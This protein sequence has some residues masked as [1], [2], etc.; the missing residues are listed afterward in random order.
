MST[1]TPPT[2][3][4]EAPQ[5]TTVAKDNAPTP[6]Q[7][8]SF[9]SLSSF[10]DV[11]ASMPVTADLHKVDIGGLEPTKAA[12][13]SGAPGDLEKAA[14]PK[15]KDGKVEGLPPNSAFHT[16]EIT[17]DELFQRKANAEGQV[18]AENE[19]PG[20]KQPLDRVQNP[21]ENSASAE[22]S[23]PAFGIEKLDT[24]AKTIRDGKGKIKSVTSTFEGAEV[25]FDFGKNGEVTRTTKGPVGNSEVA[26]FGA[27]GKQISREERD[28]SGKVVSRKVDKNDSLKVEKGRDGKISSIS[29]EQQGAK[30]KLNLDKDGNVTFRS[31]KQG[32]I[33]MTTNF[34]SSGD[35]TRNVATEYHENGNM[36]QRSTLTPGH[37]VNE[38]MDSDGRIVESEDIT[39]DAT[40]AWKQ[41]KD[42]SEMTIKDDGDGTKTEIK[43]KDGNVIFTHEVDSEG[44]NSV[45]HMKNP[46]GSSTRTTETKESLSSWTVRPDGSWENKE[47]NKTNGFTRYKVGKSP[48]D[49]GVEQRDS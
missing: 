29:T 7:D 32:N 9:K 33:E 38:K 11:K 37:E 41:L 28:E 26:K 31:V 46:D 39:E 17:F 35:A 30:M 16:P 43:D 44:E 49:P 36:K 10:N 21:G 3:H 19:T 24:S 42:G 4:V 47:T 15:I 27:N 13:A 5:R 22:S 1:N 40:T 14:G 20:L 25:S 48:E 2:E 18:F 23:E 12:M 34:D 6:A 45:T 8:D